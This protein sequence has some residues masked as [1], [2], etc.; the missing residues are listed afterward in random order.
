MLGLDS[1]NRGVENEQQQEQPTYMD[2]DQ[3]DEEPVRPTT[4]TNSPAEQTAAPANDANE[5]SFDHIVVDNDESGGK[6]TTATAKNSKID[7]KVD[8]DGY[9]TVLVS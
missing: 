2:L 6:A 5:E 8:T 3:V 1:S 4:E 9:V 7:P